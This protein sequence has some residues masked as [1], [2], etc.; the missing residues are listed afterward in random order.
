M[1]HARPQAVGWARSRK[2]LGSPGATSGLP[3]AIAYNS[4]MIRR[5]AI[6]DVPALGKIINDAAEYGQM[7][8]RSWAYLYEHVRDFHV[9]VDDAS[10]QVVGVCGLNIIWATM[11]EVYA[12]AVSPACRGQGIGRR[13]VLSCIDEAEELGIARL[14]ALTYERSFFAKLGFVVVDRQSLPL[15]VWSECVRCAKNQACD[16]I[17][18]VRELDEVPAITAPPPDAPPPGEYE[19]PVVLTAGTR[20]LG[21]QREKM[22]E[23]H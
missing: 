13:L 9:A 3:D 21:E 1:R 14:M 10:Q 16:E 17:A 7:L 20:P 23:A 8:H 19:V 18:M 11:A 5:A 4:P 15:K 12:L 2:R 6:A 22:D